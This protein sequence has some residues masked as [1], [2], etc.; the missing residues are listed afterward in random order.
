MTSRKIT[1]LLVT[2]SPDGTD[3]L[4]IETA[5]GT[6]AVP[7]QKVVDEAAGKIGTGNA[8]AS[9]LTKLYTGT[10][11]N[12]DG[13]MTQSAIKTAL[14]GKS[15]YNHTHPYAG[16]ASSGGMASSAAKLGNTSAIGSATKPVYFSSGGIPVVCNYELNKTVPY[17]AK[18]T[19]TNTTYEVATTSSNGL[20]SASD[21]TKLDDMVIEVTGIKGD[22]ET[23]YR[24]GNVN[25]T[26]QNIGLGNVN[27]TLDSNKNVNTAKSLK[28]NITWRAPIN[29]NDSVIAPMI[30]I[31]DQNIYLVQVVPVGTSM[32]LVAFYIYYA[33]NSDRMWLSPILNDSGIEVEPYNSGSFKINNTNSSKIEV[34]FYKLL[35][36]PQS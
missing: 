36:I 6:R 4:L 12:T 2:T 30:Q 35:S 3:L 5:D 25:I 17:D 27:N 14:D 10:G 34:T 18:F 1:D 21:K 22:A 33:K 16:A 24:K 19:D 28:M 11:T 32:E 26:P 8:S 20:M 7:L 31:S 9:G 23:T 15:N 29:A 13:T